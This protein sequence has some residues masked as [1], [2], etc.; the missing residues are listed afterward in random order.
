M[1][2]FVFV[3]VCSCSTAVVVDDVVSVFECVGSVV[4]V[5]FA[6]GFFSFTIRFNSSRVTVGFTCLSQ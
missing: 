2:V 5:F 3:F 6:S 1:F 4:V